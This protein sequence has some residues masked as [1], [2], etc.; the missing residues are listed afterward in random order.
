MLRN[1]A[2]IAC[3]FSLLSTMNTQAD[4]AVR[5][6]V[7]PPR[8]EATPDAQTNI[9][10]A[11]NSAQPVLAIEPT[12][13]VGLIDAVKQCSSTISGWDKA[14][15]LQDFSQEEAKINETATL[16]AKRGSVFL[17]GSYPIVNASAFPSTG[18]NV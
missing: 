13:I 7:H 12:E 18:G 4:V 14:R 9:L 15:F 1:R 2:Y 10:G 5:I 3:A 16:I 8:V 6:E 11:L 17:S